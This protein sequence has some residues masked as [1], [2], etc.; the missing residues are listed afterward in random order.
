[1]Q[2]LCSKYKFAESCDSFKMLVQLDWPESGS[3][4]FQGIANK[5]NYAMWKVDNHISIKEQW[6]QVDYD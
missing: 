6:S 4:N 2:Y 5:Q 3:L 1:M